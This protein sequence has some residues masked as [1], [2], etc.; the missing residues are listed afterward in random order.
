MYKSL[1]VLDHINELT[2]CMSQP[3]SF[4][5][6]IVR[7]SVAGCAK[8]AIEAGPITKRCGSSSDDASE[9]T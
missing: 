5:T 9:S 3:W 7:V 4:E 2:E 1:G 6:S 8:I